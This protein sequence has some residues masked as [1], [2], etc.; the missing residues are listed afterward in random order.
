LIELIEKEELRGCEAKEFSEQSSEEGG[1][2]G[3]GGF[4]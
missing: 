3:G 2:F 4:S 1:E